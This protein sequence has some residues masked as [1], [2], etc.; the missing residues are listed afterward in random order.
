MAKH[1]DQKKLMARKNLIH[2][3][4]HSTSS[5]ELRAAQGSS[6]KEYR[7]GAQGSSGQ[8][9]RAVT[10]DRST[11]ELR[12]SQGRNIGQEL[13]TKAQGSHMG[14]KLLE[15]DTMEEH[16]LLACSLACSQVHA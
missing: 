5:R 9:P 4:V 10:R 14:Q 12:E 1:S 16:C 3:T 15:A 11:R 2:L 13:R 7:A 6:G 8:E